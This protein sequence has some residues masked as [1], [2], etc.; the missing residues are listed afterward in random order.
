MWLLPSPARAR[1]AC[2]LPGQRLSIFS[3]LAPERAKKLCIGVHGFAENRENRQPLDRERDLER[4]TETE[5]KKSQTPR[6]RRTILMGDPTHFSVLG[7]ANPHT[8]DA[9]GRKKAVDANL[10]RRQ[11]H[12]LA[13][14]LV[15]HGVEICVIEPRPR[16]TG[17]VY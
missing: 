9:L 16:L 11:W 3:I 8:R 2:P 12:N 14:A 15:A 7:G 6:M 17:L 5:P 10:A 4:D 1:A 13:G